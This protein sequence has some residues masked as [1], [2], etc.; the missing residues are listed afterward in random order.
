MFKT[1][2][3]HATLHARVIYCIQQI[4]PGQKLPQIIQN[5]LSL[6]LQ[7]GDRET[8]TETER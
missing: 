6:S 8:G 4:R 3:R 5:I 2:E 1:R 7:R